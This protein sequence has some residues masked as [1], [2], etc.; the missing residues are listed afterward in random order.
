MSD[1]EK[2]LRAEVEKTLS[3]VLTTESAMRDWLKRL[4]EW[5]D[6]NGP[7]APDAKAF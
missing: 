7:P 2:T 6:R 4:R 1:L 3:L 5:N